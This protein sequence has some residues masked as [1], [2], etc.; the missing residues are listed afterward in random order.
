MKKGK[1]GLAGLGYWGKNVLRNLYELGVLGAAYDTDPNTV[2][3]WRKKYPEVRFVLSMDELLA[4]P[5]IKA[6]AVATP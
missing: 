2:A 1:I 4:D 6:V 5:G 3:E